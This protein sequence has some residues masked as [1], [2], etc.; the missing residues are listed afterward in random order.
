MLCLYL[1]CG[2][3]NGFC[4]A[5]T[6]PY[7]DLDLISYFLFNKNDEIQYHY[8]SIV[9]YL[10]FK[11]GLT[12]IGSIKLWIRV[13]ENF[14]YERHCCQKTTL[15]FV[16]SF[17]WVQQSVAKYNLSQSTIEH[18]KSNTLK[19]MD[20]GFLQNCKHFVFWQMWHFKIINKT[21]ILLLK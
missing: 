1:F 12:L 15:H 16:V 8:A 10:N 18:R 2:I 7:L 9:W 13:K 14:T 6:K 4:Q 20:C 5:L 21:N 11:M 17:V 3:Y 19:C